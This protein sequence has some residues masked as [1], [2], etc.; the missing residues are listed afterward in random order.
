MLVSFRGAQTVHRVMADDHR[1]PS[2]ADPHDGDV[3]RA[4]QRVGRDDRHLEVASLGDV[5]AVDRIAVVLGM[6]PA[7]KA[8]TC[9]IA[10]GDT[11]VAWMRSG[12]K[13]ATALPP[14]MMTT[15][16]PA[17]TSRRSF[18]RCVMAWWTPT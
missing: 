5:N 4:N 12:T 8:C 14:R 18:D 9:S 2:V 1:G 6:R 11:P 16:D 3:V 15:S 7:A 10:K 17:S 13:R